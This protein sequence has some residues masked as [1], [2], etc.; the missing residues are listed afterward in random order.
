MLVVVPAAEGR[1]I[2]TALLR[3]ADD[4]GRTNGYPWLTLNVFE[5]NGRA[6]ALYERLG[7]RPETLRYLRPL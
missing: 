6:R 7:Y 1:G 4:W 2:A 3:A 5:G